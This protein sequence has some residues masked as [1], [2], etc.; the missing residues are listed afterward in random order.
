MHQPR[1]GALPAEPCIENG[2]Q[3]VLMG[4]CAGMALNVLR[5]HLL[6]RASG[7]SWDMARILLKMLL[8]WKEMHLSHATAPF[9]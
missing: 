9:S 5:G 2:S 4:S 6:E 3:G 1:K 7:W 8:D